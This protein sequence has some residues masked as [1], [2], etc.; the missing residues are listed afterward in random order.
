LNGLSLTAPGALKAALIDAGRGTGN[1]AREQHLRS[2]S[3]TRR[4]FDGFWCRGCNV[5][6]AHGGFPSLYRRERNA[7]S[8]RHLT[9]NAGRRSAMGPSLFLE[10]F[11]V[12][13]KLLTFKLGRCY[14]Q[15]RPLRVQAGQYR[16]RQGGLTRWDIRSLRMPRRPDV[17]PLATAASAP[18]SIFK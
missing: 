7:L 8:R 10:K 5:E 6:M 16:P 3:H 12:W 13:S 14:F 2:T 17:H 15:N 11:R 4:T 18:H 1:D 9:R